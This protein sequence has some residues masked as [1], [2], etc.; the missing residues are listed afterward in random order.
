M[1]IDYQA[2]PMAMFPVQGANLEVWRQE[3]IH[4]V[5]HDVQVVILLLPGGKNGSDLYHD[6]KK[7]LL[8]EVPVVS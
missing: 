6:L 2:K 5:K 4:K 7:M 8:E 3:I 1:S